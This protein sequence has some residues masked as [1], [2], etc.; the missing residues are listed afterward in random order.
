MRYE[1]FHTGPY[2]IFSTTTS[3]Q[4][5]LPCIDSSDDQNYQYM[6]TRLLQKVQRFTTQHPTTAATLYNSFNKIFVSEIEKIN[7]LR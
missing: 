6:L 5:I 7:K 3:L 4:S 1:P 2:I